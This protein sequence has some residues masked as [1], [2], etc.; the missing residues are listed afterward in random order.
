[1]DIVVFGNVAL[2]VICQTVE[3]VPL[4]ESIGFERAAV[5]AGGCASNV[6]V[7]LAAL[8]AQVGLAARLG[9]DEAAGLLES[10]WR[11]VG[12]DSRWAHRVNGATTGVSIGLVDHTGQPRFV[13]TPG[14]SAGLTVDDLDLPAIVQAG[15]RALHVAGFFVLPGLCDGR[16]PATLAQA[17]HLGLHTSLDVVRSPGMDDPAPLWPCLPYLDLFLCNS[18]EA[19]R[20]TG[21]IQPDQAAQALRQAGA[22]SVVVKLSSQGSWAASASFTGLV[23]AVPAPVVDTTGAGDAFDAG[24]LAARLHGAGLEEACRAGNAAGRRMVG[25]LGAVSGWFSGK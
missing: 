8:G 25:S 9:E 23:A 10:F 21:E 16:L 19:A 7:G 24:L 18:W 11:R 12:V 14:A 5:S 13:H 22:G 20:L 6:A 1:M 4:E 2:D 3:E 15:A 17:R